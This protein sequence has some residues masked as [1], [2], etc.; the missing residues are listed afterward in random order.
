MQKILNNYVDLLDHRMKTEYNNNIRI[1]GQEEYNSARSQRLRF[2]FVR[3]S[4][5][6]E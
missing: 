6:D 2:A 1:K 3:E 5:P 4:K